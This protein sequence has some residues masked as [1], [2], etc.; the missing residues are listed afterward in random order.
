MKIDT[1]ELASV[2]DE[3]QRTALP[4]FMEDGSVRIHAMVYEHGSLVAAAF[5]NYRKKLLEGD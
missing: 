2:M 3:L 1:E 5:S 4:E